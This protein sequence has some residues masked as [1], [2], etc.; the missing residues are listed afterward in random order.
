[1]KA[2]FVQTGSSI[3]YTPGSAVAAGD[4]IVVGNLVAVAK[5]DIPANTLGALSVVG[6][7]D[8]EKAE[9]AVFAIGDNVYFDNSAKVATDVATGN[10]YMGR[11]IAAAAAAAEGVN[12]KVRL[13]LNAPGLGPIG[14]PGTPGAPGAPGAPGED[15]VI[16]PAN[17]IAD[18]NL[19]GAAGADYVKAELDA[20]FGALETKVNAILAALRTTGIVAPNA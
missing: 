7:Y 2:V 6:V 12:P 20:D 14:T 19:T 9:A 4:V 13:V 16:E 18:A 10:K 8:V 3:D 17:A 15:A 1:M 5:L 11:A